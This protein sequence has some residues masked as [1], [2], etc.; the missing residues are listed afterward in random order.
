MTWSTSVP[1]LTTMVI[2]H[3]SRWSFR[4]ILGY[5]QWRPSWSPM[6]WSCNVIGNGTIWSAIPK[7]LGVA[8]WILS[9]SVLEQK[10]QAKM[11]LTGGGRWPFWNPRWRP[12]GGVFYVS[13]YL[14]LNS[15][16]KS[17]CVP[18]LVLVSYFAHFA[19]FWLLINA[20]TSVYLFRIHLRLLVLGH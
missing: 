15:M 1:N 18:N 20:W 2:P 9:L 13:P 8:T 10:L 4:S 16:K 7:N 12:P 5:L 19:Y 6:W 17:T 11:C 14:K 3:F